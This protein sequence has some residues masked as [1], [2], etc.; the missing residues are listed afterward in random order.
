MATRTIL[1]AITVAVI[2]VGCTS[3]PL[4]PDGSLLTSQR[5]DGTGVCRV[6]VNRF[7]CVH[8]VCYE[9]DPDETHLAR[10]KHDIHIVWT[11][12]A[13]DY[14]CKDAGYGVFLKDPGDNDGQFEDQR[15][16][17]KDTGDSTSE[18]DCKKHRHFHWKAKNTLPN[19]DYKYKIIFFDKNGIPHLIDPWI[20]ND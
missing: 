5:C 11:L 4:H 1:S 6:K 16:T 7:Q 14:F 3:L 17:D 8:F 18:T 19:K 10:G 15:S 9:V 13:G 2:L 20:Y 12:E